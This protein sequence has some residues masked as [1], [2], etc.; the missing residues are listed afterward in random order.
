VPV[1]VRADLV[2]FLIRGGG[3]RQRV[4]GEAGIRREPDVRPATWVP[5]R[6][7]A[8]V[9]RPIDEVDAADEE[10]EVRVHA[11]GDRAPVLEHVGATRAVERD[12]DELRRAGRMRWW[13]DVHP[14]RGEQG[15]CQ[16]DAHE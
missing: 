3:L 12:D 4:L 5:R 16:D 10:G 15:H 9:V 2:P 11:P 8:L 6:R 7:V 13:C 14:A 1:E